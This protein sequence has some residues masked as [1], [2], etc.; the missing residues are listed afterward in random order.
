MPSRS[1]TTR[2]SSSSSASAAVATS[3]PRPVASARASR[4]RGRRRSSAQ[5]TPATPAGGSRAGC[6]ER[7]LDSERVEDVAAPPTGAA[8]ARSRASVPPPRSSQGAPGHREHV[9]ADRERVVGRDQRAGAARRLDDDRRLGERRDDAVADGKAPRRGLDARPPLRDDRAGRGDARRERRVA[10]RV[11][12]VDAAAEHRDRAAAAVE[13]ARMAGR[14]DA[15][16]EAADHAHARL[17]QLARERAREALARRRRRAGADHRDGRAARRPRPARAG[18]ARAGAWARRR[19]RCAR[20]AGH[21]A[22][23]RSSTRTGGFIRAPAARDEGERLGDVLA[24]DAAAA[25]RDRRPSAPGAGRAPAGARSG[26]ATTAA[27]S[28]SS[29]ASGAMPR[30]SSSAS[31]SRALGIFWP[32]RGLPVARSD[33]AGGDDLGRLGPVAA[34]RLR[35]GRVDA[36]D[37][38]EP[39]DQ[40]SAEARAVALDAL[41]RC[42]CSRRARRR[43]RGSRPRRAARAPESARGRPRARRPA[44]RPRAAAA[45]ASSALRENSVSSSRKSTPPVASEISPGRGPDAAADE[46]RRRRA[47]VRRAER[48]SPDRARPGTQHAG[49]RVHARHLERRLLVERR[50]QPRQPPREH[51]LAHARRADHEHVVAAHRGQLERAARERLAA[52][53]GEIGPVGARRRPGRRRHAAARARRAATPRPRSGDARRARAR[54]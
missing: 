35:V 51:R 45:S 17:G 24:R 4:R 16:R 33:D 30:R 27:R 1:S 21:S 39:V 12:A 29:R 22:A 13:R 25:R 37:E 31:S 50:Q 3:A 54:P 14:V 46:R 42:R 41:V 52:H 40:R 49:R 5:S 7:D 48:R 34:E 9:A 23:L 20:H 32:A 11:V 53:V 43:G 18:R 36:H 26:A 10:A 15:E 38:V 2:P 8:P 47:V 28:S 6:S 44:R 19:P